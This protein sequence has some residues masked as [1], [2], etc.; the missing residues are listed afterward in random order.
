MY[1]SKIEHLIRLREHHL[2][3]PPFE[4]I[5]YD[6]LQNQTFPI[7]LDCKTYAVRSSSNL[8]DGT[9]DSFAGQFETYLNVPKSE[10]EEKIKLC[11]DSMHQENVLTYM[12][13]KNIPKDLIQMNVLI[14]EMV[15]SELSGVIFSANPQGLLNETVIVVGQGLGEGIV[16]DR[17]DATSYYYNQTDHLY[18][19]EG[20]QDYL[21]E[22]QLEELL[23]LTKQIQ[24]I[25]G[26][27]MDIEF[28]IAKNKI[29]I[30]QARKITT[31][32]DK[33]PLILDNSNIVE[34]YPGLSLPLT[35]SFVNSVYGGVFEG[36]SR[37]ILRDEEELKKHKAIFRNMVGSANGRLYYKISNWYTLIQFLPFHKKIIPIWQ[38]MLGVKTKTYSENKIRLRMKTR[39][40]TYIHAFSELV[41]VPKSMEQLEI[42]FRDIYRDFYQTLEKTSSTQEILTLY[43]EVETKLLSCWDITLVNDLYAFLF[44]GFLKKRQKTNAN[45]SISGITNLESLNPIR[46]LVH[47]A[48]M[49][50]RITTVE[51]EQAFNSFIEQYGDRNLEELKLESATFRT[52]PN[53]LHMRIAEYRKDPEKLEEL[54]HNL[55]DA[56]T[57][58]TEKPNGLINR[59]L[60][61]HAFIGICNREASRLNR[62]RIYGMVRSMML[63]IGTFF[64]KDGIVSDARDIFYLT[65][66]EIKELADSKTPMQ[67]IVTQR[68]SAYDMYQCLPAY[69]RLVFMEKEFDKVHQSINQHSCPSDA[70]FLTGTPCSAGVAVAE[71]LVIT[72]VTKVQNV[73]DKILITKMTDPGWVFLL[74]NA[75]GVISEKGSLLSHTAII[76]RELKIPSI[77]GVNQL[78]E[79]IKTGDIIR[80]DGERGTIERIHTHQI[81]E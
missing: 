56:P 1:G 47:L 74:A 24:E 68:K 75:K 78:L 64:E 81:S 55:Y 71:A 18:Y 2:P 54:H 36:L 3:V 5:S 35:I 61:K 23:R 79:S 30:L 14:Q 59:W 16:S 28:A 21:T 25:L 62:S 19:Y 8:E 27:Y 10:L 20:K 73:T 53:L 40:L 37:R 22:S 15:D 41:R 44:T 46:E 72:D 4:I 76:S 48:Y 60:T 31:V 45:D 6:M 80:M 38:E 29:Y 51:Y 63:R 77:V 42:H 34:S 13:K 33:T 69:S 49:K 9:T 39:F 11:F 43:D 65:L 26:Q 52:N 67:R 17:V 7:H 70:C 66:D 57:G 58:M 32:S 50:D 12:D